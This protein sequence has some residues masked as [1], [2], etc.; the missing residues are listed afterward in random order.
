MAGYRIT[1]PSI[2][3]L[4]SSTAANGDLFFVFDITADATKRMAFSEFVAFAKTTYDAAYATASDISNALTNYV[5]SANLSTTLGSYVTSSALTTTLVDYMPK[6][7][8]TF[9]GAVTGT[10]VNA[11][12]PRSAETVGTLTAASANAVVVLSGN[13]TLP[14][15]VF[16]ADT[17]ILLVPGAANRTVTRGASL[18]MMHDGSDTASV[19]A[20]ANTVV[21]VLYVTTTQCV[22]VGAYDV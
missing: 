11:R 20:N 22:V 4:G 19:I 8:G 10:T 13:V 1:D 9:T 18:V 6:A 15:N 21:A 16:A 14:A 12:P 7:G 5:T 2:G 17:I 3:V